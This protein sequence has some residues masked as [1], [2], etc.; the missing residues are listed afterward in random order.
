T[1][2]PN[3]AKR[4][5]R[6]T[7]RLVSGRWELLRPDR[8]SRVG[9][10]KTRT[11]PWSNRAA[12]EQDGWAMLAPL[13]PDGRGGLLSSSPPPRGEVGGAGEASPCRKRSPLTPNPSP[14]RGEGR[15]APLTAG[16]PVAWPCRAAEWSGSR[17]C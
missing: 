14:P 12:G 17:P 3:H 16:R 6:K 11:L 1:T 4:V 7:P 13:P 15:F 10:E 2:T 9:K 8:P 5:I